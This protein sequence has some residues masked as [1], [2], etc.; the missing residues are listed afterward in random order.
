MCAGETHVQE[1]LRLHYLAFGNDD[2][3]TSVAAT[4]FAEGLLVG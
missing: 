1:G 4:A 2:R 3:F